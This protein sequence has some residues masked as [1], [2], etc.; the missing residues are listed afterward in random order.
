VPKIA[1]F[2]SVL[3][4]RGNESKVIVNS[5]LSLTP[6]QLTS[7][8]EENPFSYFHIF[9]P[10]FHFSPN[11][12]TGKYFSFGRNYYKQLLAGDI[13][14]EDSKSAFYLYQMT[15]VD[16]SDFTGLIACVD[17]N[18]YEKGKIKKH[19][20]T[21]V[22]KEELLASH[23]AATDLI[24]EPVLLSYND[25]VYV[26]L[27]SFFS[28]IK[29]Q[30]AH[31]TFETAD[32]TQHKLW[33]VDNIEWI[34]K[35]I[36]SCAHINAFYIADGHHRCA[37][38]HRYIKQRNISSDSM[39]AF[40]VPAS[41]LKIYPFYRYFESSNAIDINK[42]TLQLA[43][44]FLIVP[45]ERTISA[46]EQDEILMLHQSCAYKLKFKKITHG[47]GKTVDNLNVAILEK[48]IFNAVLDIQDSRTDNRL[49][50]HSAKNLN[51]DII[52]SYLSQTNRIVF[53]LAPI[54]MEEIFKVSDENSVMPPKST[55]VEP[56]LYSGA[57]IMEFPKS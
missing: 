6:E 17:S 15:W 20:N 53:A 29:Q 11:D 57:V 55:Y 8:L 2:K 12:T 33:K 40:I 7:E 24:G 44:D 41:Q 35:L 50:F 28:E 22:E 18:D 4:T 47:I 26:D 23:I 56:K 36:N 32:Q 16:G 37:S 5:H 21:L 51:L 43:D 13:L 46:I 30:K 49:S 38:M 1:P 10:Q 34:E 31:R 54:Q 52:N 39:L 9:K 27:D 42:L 19:E 3:P 45:I 48:Y 14:T 25:G